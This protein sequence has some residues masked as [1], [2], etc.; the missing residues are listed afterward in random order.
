MTGLTRPRIGRNPGHPSGRS[1]DGL[2]WTLGARINSAI[3]GAAA[4]A[5][6][7]LIA[8]CSP[9]GAGAPVRACLAEGG[10]YLR[11]GLHGELALALD[12]PNEG[13]SCTG[14]RRP[15]EGARLRFARG[16]LADGDSLVVIL[17]IDGLEPGREASSLPTT[18]TII[19]ERASRFYSNQDRESCWSD[20]LEH[21]PAAGGAA[22]VEGRTYCTGAL[23]EVNGTGSVTPAELSFRG[24][25]EWEETEPVR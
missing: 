19:D 1:G 2:M 14:M 12:W 24:R 11:G 23:G 6:A 5:A 8:A 3:P 18:V 16:V 10:G 7:A 17:G 4:V 22:V 9:D 25:I 13:T 20:V 15:G 21:A